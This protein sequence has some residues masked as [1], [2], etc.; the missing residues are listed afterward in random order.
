MD[1]SLLSLRTFTQQNLKCWPCQKSKLQPFVFRKV[2]IWQ[3]LLANQLRWFEYNFRCL[4]WL[5]S[6]LPQK[7]WSAF[8]LKQRFLRIRLLV[9]WLNCL[10]TCG[11]TRMDMCLCCQD[12]VYASCR[13]WWYC[14]MSKRTY[15]HAL[16]LPS[17]CLVHLAADDNLVICWNTRMEICLCCQEDV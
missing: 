13:W 4:K 10:F 7:L 11:N 15:E 6:K 16:L 14:Y 17:R 9:T 12:D 5:A 8:L 2:P 3:R 1:L